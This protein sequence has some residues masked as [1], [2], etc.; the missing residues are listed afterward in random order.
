MNAFQT[1]DITHEFSVER[2]RSDKKAIDDGGVSMSPDLKLPQ[3]VEALLSAPGSRGSIHRSPDG[4]IRSV[5]LVSYH[6]S[7]IEVTIMRGGKLRLGWNR[8]ACGLALRDRRD[9]QRQH[10]TG[11][12]VLM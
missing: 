10:M 9:E 7:L 1:R 8:S 12:S 6:P 11:H 3:V 2:E 5:L 4:V